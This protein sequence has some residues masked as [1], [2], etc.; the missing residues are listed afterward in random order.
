MTAEPRSKFAPSGESCFLAASRSMRASHNACILP[1]SSEA[2][3][4]PR[5]HGCSMFTRGET[6]AI[7]VVT[8]GG[9]ADAQRVDELTGTEKNRRFYLAYYFP[10]SSVGEVRGHGTACLRRSSRSASEVLAFASKAADARMDAPARDPQTGRMGGPS[11]RELGHGN[12]AE[13]AL[14]PTLPSSDDVRV[15]RASRCCCCKH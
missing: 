2:G 7:A 1:H 10:H 8:L 13:R 14:M 4:L 12:L 15:A 5:V 6:Q 11:R 3:L 9:D